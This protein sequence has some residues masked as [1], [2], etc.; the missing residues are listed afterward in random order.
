VY[1]GVVTAKVRGT[2]ARTCFDSVGFWL[3]QDG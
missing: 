3:T 1:A 2:E